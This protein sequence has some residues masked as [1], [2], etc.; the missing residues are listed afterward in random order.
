MIFKS[1]KK[2][3]LKNIRVYTTEKSMGPF[4]LVTLI[5]L[6]EKRC[7]KGVAGLETFKSFLKTTEKN[8]FCFQLPVVRLIL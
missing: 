7:L 2:K 5:G 1:S 4:F 3:L 6:K 8:T